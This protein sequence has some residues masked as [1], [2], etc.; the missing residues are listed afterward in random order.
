[1]ADKKSIRDYQ[2]FREDEAQNYLAEHW[3]KGKLTAKRFNGGSKIYDYIK[4]L[5]RFISYISSQIF[6][7]AQER[8]IQKAD[9]YLEDWE[10]SVKIPEEIPRRS[11]IEGQRNA[12]QCLVSKIPVYNIDDG[13]VDECTTFEYYVECLTG[14]QVSMRTARVDG[15]GSIFP[16][17]FPFRFGTGGPKGN[18]IFIVTVPVVGAPANNFFPL[19]FPV[20]FFTPVIPQ[21]TMELLDLVLDRVVPSFCRWQYEVEVV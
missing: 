17:E 12:V 5:A 7:F 4:A 10:K 3:P 2:Y 11:T 16:M 1:M 15:T 18:F 6:I 14:I 9:V 13:I 20:Q 19:P 8:D 21:A